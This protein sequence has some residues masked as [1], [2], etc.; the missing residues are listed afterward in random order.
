MTL[1]YQ[2][3]TKFVGFFSQE[4]AKESQVLSVGKQQYTPEAGNCVHVLTTLL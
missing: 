4:F 1:L 3:L 2:T